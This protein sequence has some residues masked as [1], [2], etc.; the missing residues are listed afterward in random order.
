MEHVEAD[1]LIGMNGEG[2]HVGN[3]PAPL[4]LIP[5]LGSPA[6]EGGLRP[7]EEEPVLMRMIRRI[8]ARDHLARRRAKR[9]DVAGAGV[10]R[11]VLRGLF[12]RLFVIP[13]HESIPVAHFNGGVA[14]EAAELGGGSSEE[15]ETSAEDGKKF[16]PT[17]EHKKSDAVNPA[18]GPGFQKVPE[19][20]QKVA[21]GGPSEA[22]GTPGWKSTHAKRPGGAREAW[23]LPTTG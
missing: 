8:I 11:I 7:G 14:L 22:S 9:M 10:E 3:A 13:H 1:L 23:R 21:G 17:R 5:K 6:I 15:K 12:A 2:L 4:F 18:D 19:G 20:R 16:H